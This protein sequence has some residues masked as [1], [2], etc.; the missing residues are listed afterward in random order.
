MTINEKNRLENRCNDAVVSIYGDSLPLFVCV[1][2]QR[3]LEFI[4][5]NNYTRVF[6]LATDIAEYVKS[7]GYRITTRGTTGS[8]LVA[9]L[10]GIS[11]VNP[12]PPHYT[13]KS[14]YG[15]A[16]HATAWR[17][18]PI[19]NNDNTKTTTIWL[20][21][22]RTCSATRFYCTSGIGATV[23]SCHG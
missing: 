16:V 19:F 12:L 22:L 11:N 2:L 17:C 21:H 7:R 23:A 4:T 9:Y 14:W 13:C 1:R 6:T 3:E 15:R 5:T 20:H 8:S 18:L 10:L